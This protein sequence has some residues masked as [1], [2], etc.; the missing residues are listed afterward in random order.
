VP[1]A[2]LIEDV[3]NPL[4]VN[5]AAVKLRRKEIETR[6]RQPQRAAWLQDA[7]P[8]SQQTAA[9]VREICSITSSRQMTSTL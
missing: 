4:F 6:R 1:V 9:L 3:I 8:F 2:V 5:R 7:L